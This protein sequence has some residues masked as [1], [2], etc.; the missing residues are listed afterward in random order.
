[1]ARPSC[2]H[3]DGSESKSTATVLSITM[4]DTPPLV[5]DSRLSLRTTEFRIAVELATRD[6]K[7]SCFDSPNKF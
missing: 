1:M 7:Q 5:S 2:L 6:Q 4:E 3:A